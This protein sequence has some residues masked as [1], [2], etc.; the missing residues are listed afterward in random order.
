MDVFSDYNVFKV[1]ENSKSISIIVYLGTHSRCKKS[2]LY[3]TLSNSV[4]MP[5][6]LD[7]LQNAGLI[8]LV[9]DSRST[10]TL[11]QLTDTGREVAALLTKVGNLLLE[12]QS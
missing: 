9:P 5:R 4:I 11:V 12:A 2:E 7:D 3:A 10:A 8:E 1:L 6:K